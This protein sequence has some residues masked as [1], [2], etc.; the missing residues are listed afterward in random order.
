M[1]RLYL[2]AIENAR[3]H[4]EEL[5]RKIL[6]EYLHTDGNDLIIVRDKFGKPYVK[7]YPGLHF[8]IS[9][10]KAAIAFALADSPIGVDIE[11]IR[12]V[13]KSIVRHFFTQNEQDYIFL[14]N[15][16]QD[17]RFTEIWTRKEAYFKF[18]GKGIE[19]TLELFDVL[20]IQNSEIKIETRRVNYYIVSS[21]FLKN[22]KSNQSELSYKLN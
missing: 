9:H 6:G 8:N 16:G 4:S 3:N 7:N 1:I 22:S 21:C 5:A 2:Q 15:I 13:K 10:T 20:E 14:N 12:S 18:L 19:N 17:I 11:I